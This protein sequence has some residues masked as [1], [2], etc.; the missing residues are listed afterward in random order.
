M[1]LKIVFVDITSYS[2]RRSQSQADVIDSFMECLEAA[3]S[4]TAKEY[5]QYCELNTINFLNDV[6][7]LPS[8]DGAAVG[9]P[10]EG[11]HDVHLVFAK[12][13]LRNVFE[14]NSSS[15]CEKFIENN[16]CNCHSNFNLSIGISEGKGILY[17]DVNKSFN[18]AGSSINL[19]ARVM[20]LAEENQI[21]FTEDAYHQIID[22]VDDPNLDDNFT[23]F[24]GV[25][26]KHNEKINV[27]QYVEQLDYLNTE[28]PEE[29]SMSLKARE[30]LSNMTNINMSNFGNIA[31]MEKK[32]MLDVIESMQSLIEKTAEVRKTIDVVISDEDKND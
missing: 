9:F 22:M 12:N 26:I 28:P 20:N 31:N 3:R 24:K 2:K 16:W 32:K 11:L 23:S 13:L 8:G 21:I 17:R 1:N 27:Y 10:F 7:F 19:A 29:L 5:I 18:I 6:I 30:L 15:P 14:H 25:P 4:E